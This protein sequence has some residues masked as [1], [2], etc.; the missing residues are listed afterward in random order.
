MDL[1]KETLKNNGTALTGARR[2][3]PR[4]VYELEEEDEKDNKPK[5]WLSWFQGFYRRDDQEDETRPISSIQGPRTS[6]KSR[7]PEQQATVENESQPTSIL[8]KILPTSHK[9]D[10]TSNV[11]Q[12]GVS[13]TTK[14]DGPSKERGSKP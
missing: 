11:Q 7:F 5:G 2:I 8:S 14:A 10:S 12:A 1:E 13:S 3:L 6:P 4:E 9:S